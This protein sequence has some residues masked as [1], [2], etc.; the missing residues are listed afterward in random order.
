MSEYYVYIMTN[1]SGT[2]YI[3]V[4]NDLVRRVYE[5]KNKIVKGFT[6]RYNITRLMHFESTE[7]VNSAIAR[8]KTTE[9][10]DSEKENRIDRSIQPTLDRLVRGMVRVNATKL[11][12]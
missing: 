12:A 8:E 6:T 4:T 9:R 2:L 10:L 3:G 11:T 5:H 7:D 1:N